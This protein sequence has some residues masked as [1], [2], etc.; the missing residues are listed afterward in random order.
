MHDSV[1]ARDLNTL[2]D[3][4][5]AFVREVCVPLERHLLAHNYATLEARLADVRAEAQAA[6]LWN[7]YHSA[8]HGGP[9]LSLPD[10]ARISE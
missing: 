7:L 10:F 9:G 1:S 3:E 4:V 2:L 6:G 5:R 8:E